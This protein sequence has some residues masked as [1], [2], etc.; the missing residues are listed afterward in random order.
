MTPKISRQNVFIYVQRDGLTVCKGNTVTWPWLG[1]E[2]EWGLRNIS[3]WNALYVLFNMYS[4]YPKFGIQ[5]F[6]I[7]LF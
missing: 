4:R 6:V 7:T 1:V 2:E 3:S 5:P